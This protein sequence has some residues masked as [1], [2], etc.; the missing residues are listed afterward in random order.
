MSKDASET[1]NI[2]DRAPSF[3]LPNQKGQPRALE[4]ALRHGP[5][6]LGFHRGTW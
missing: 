6:L 5:V 4:D 3:V 1:L 2:G